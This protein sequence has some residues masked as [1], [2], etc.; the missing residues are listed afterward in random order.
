MLVAAMVPEAE[1]AEVATEMSERTESD[2]L[3]AAMAT[4]A[5]T[6]EV[7]SPEG[8]RCR[9]RSHGQQRSTSAGNTAPQSTRPC[10]CNF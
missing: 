7:V 8:S 1:M 10:E 4:E 6:V 9:R 3:E 5:E 2:T